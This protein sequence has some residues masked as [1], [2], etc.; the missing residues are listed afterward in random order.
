MLYDPRPIWFA[1]QG[2]WNKTGE[3]HLRGISVSLL[4]SHLC[5]S[6]TAV[7]S[8]SGIDEGSVSMWSLFITMRDACIGIIPKSMPLGAA[9]GGSYSP[10]SRCSQKDADTLS[11]LM[12]L[13]L[14]VSV[15]ARICQTWLSR[16]WSTSGKLLLS[17]AV[18]ESLGERL[19]LDEY[20]QSF[21]DEAA[22]QHL[23]EVLLEDQP[24]VHVSSLV[25]RQWYAKYHPDSGPLRFETGAAAR[26]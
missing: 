17:E 1:L 26:P 3:Q 24:P 22:A 4:G 2:D 12:L 7:E 6:W 19:R 20:K 9:L 10:R 8:C 15:S 14:R 21:A 11:K 16:D 23:A 18:E 13:S 5:R 25:L